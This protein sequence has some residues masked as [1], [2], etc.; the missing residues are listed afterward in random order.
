MDEEIAK[1]LFLR[2]SGDGNTVSVRDLV[3]ALGVGT[4]AVADDADA[5]RQSS[6]DPFPT[7]RVCACACMRACLCICVCVCVCLSVCLLHAHARTRSHTHTLS[8]SRF[9]LATDGSGGV[10]QEQAEAVLQR[11]GA[12][13]GEACVSFEKVDQSAATTRSIPHCN[14]APAP[15]ALHR[16][17]N[18]TTH[19]TRW[20]LVSV[21]CSVCRGTPRA[22]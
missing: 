6:Q 18:V 12:E 9:L 3:K 4:D 1:A 17:H 16:A 19:K 14:V 8:L 21:V 5:D 11:L 7:V 13:E 15:L 20:L 2:L 22:G 10:M